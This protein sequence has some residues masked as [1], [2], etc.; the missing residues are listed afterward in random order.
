M[1]PADA[2]QGQLIASETGTSGLSAHSEEQAPACRS[3]ELIN[4][5]WRSS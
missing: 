2:A 5:P 4:Q 1:S 3:H